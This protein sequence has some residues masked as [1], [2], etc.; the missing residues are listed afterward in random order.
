VLLQWNP[1]MK[2]RYLASSL[3]VMVLASC[4]TVHTVWLPPEKEEAFL[5]GGRVI[6]VKESASSPG[7]ARNIRCLAEDNRFTGASSVNNRAVTLILKGNYQ[8]AEALLDILISMEPSYAPAYNN[9]GVLMEY[10]ERKHLSLDNYM[11]ARL[12]D[13]Y[14]RCYKENA[15]L[16]GSNVQ[17]EE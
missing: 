12:L 3:I 11:N 8:E 6:L 5:S 2:L 1:V 15:S 14:N 7:R 16:A 17:S 13:S 10:T 4:Q 9:L